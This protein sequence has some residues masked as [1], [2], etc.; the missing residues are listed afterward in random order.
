[1]RTSGDGSTMSTWSG[2]C[3]ASHAWIA[4]RI[5]GVEKPRARAT[6]RNDAMI[7]SS[8]FASSGGAV[9]LRLLT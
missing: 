6:S 1:M 3:C 2:G 8:S 5:A 7:S 4:S 9:W